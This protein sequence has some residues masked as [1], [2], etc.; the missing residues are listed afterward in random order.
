MANNRFKVDNGLAVSGNAEFYQRIDA[1][2][3]AH[4]NN[5]LF[6]VSGN[7]VV[8]GTLIYANVV[9]GNGGIRAVAD[10]QDLGNTTNRFNL[11]GYRVQIDD[12]L[13]PLANG[14]AVGNTTRRFEVFA[15]NLNATTITV[16]AGGSINATY[17]NG[18][19]SNANTVGNLDANGIIVRTGTATAVARSVNVSSNGI[20]ITNGD[21]LAGNPT[22]A[23]AFGAGMFANTTGMFVN[24]SS[25]SV[26]T[27][28]I[29]RGGTGGPDRVTGLNNLLPTQNVA[30]ADYV[31]RTD[32]TNASWV[33]AT[34][35]T[36]FTGSV[37][38]IGFT[39]SVG[40]VG[41]TGSFG[42]QGFTGSVGF[43]GSAGTNGFW[44]SAGAVGFTGSGGLGYTGSVGFTGSAGTAGFWGS[45]GGVGFTGSASTVIGFTGSRGFTGSAST[46]KGFTGSAG[47]LG[48]TGSQPSLTAPILRN[49]TSGY[50]GGGQV[51]VSSSTPTASAAGDIWIQI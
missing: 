13:V 23:L 35:P 40:A 33:L 39:G 31:L 22:L 43:T 38:A 50:T 47:A 41:F 36:G 20:T 26:G 24:L 6:V 15:N 49:V 14:V 30:V 4:F 46:D 29:S 27:L 9:I 11:F 44:G 5:D 28:P 16:G 7:L 1:H 2:A 12:T 10:Q 51:F 8:N 34:G 25:L 21:G 45:S 17:F 3:N 48:Y 42:T 37:G 32:G 19:A 18:T